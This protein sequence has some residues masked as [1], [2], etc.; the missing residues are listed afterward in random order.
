MKEEQES[1]LQKHSFDIG[2]V[3]RDHVLT[4]KEMHPKHLHANYVGSFIKHDS[5]DHFT[6]E[7]ALGFC[8]VSKALAS[9]IFTQLIPC[10]QHQQRS[11]R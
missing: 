10:A 5:N 1:I 7:N 4:T 6:P 8:R 9:L 3:L 11:Q 2:D